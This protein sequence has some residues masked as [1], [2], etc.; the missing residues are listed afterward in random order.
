M[1]QISIVEQIEQAFIQRHILSNG[2]NGWRLPDLCKLLNL[3]FREISP[4]INQMI[5]ANK[6]RVSKSMKADLYYL[7]V[8]FSN[9]EMF[10]EEI[11]KFRPNEPKIE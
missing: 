6:L 10:K 7:I 11:Q 3:S 9:P 2:H 5:K 8:G 4:I 1:A